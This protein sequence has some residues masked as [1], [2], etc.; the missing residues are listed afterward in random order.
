MVAMNLVPG[1]WQ[2]GE[3]VFGN[4]TPYPVSDVK[5]QTYNVNKQDFQVA[6]SNEISFGLDTRAAGTLVFTLGVEDNYILDS[7]KSLGNTHIPSGFE[8]YYKDLLTKLQKEWKADDVIGVWGAV[9]PLRYCDRYDRTRRVLGRPRK[10]TYTKQTRTSSYYN[11]TAEYQRLDTNTYSDIEYFTKLTNGAAA[12]MI[13]R[14]DGDADSWFRVLLDGPQTNP[15]IF[16]GKVQIELTLE[17]AAGESVEV[18]TYP[19]TRRI[20]QFNTTTGGDLLNQRTALTG[21]SQYL[22]QMTIPPSESVAMT[23]DA[24][25]TTDDSACAVLWRDAFNVL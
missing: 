20:V 25:D 17:L 6:R 22:D 1:Q 2:I 19:G 4:R 14:E 23:W 13:T 15:K 18:N 12:V 8:D 7:M 9:K 10:F 16:I 5:V 24:E 21:N 11:V 3:V